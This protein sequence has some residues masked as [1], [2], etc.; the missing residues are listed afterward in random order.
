M[1]RRRLG[2]RGV[3]PQHALARE[4]GS[5]YHALPSY[6]HLH[7]REPDPLEY[8]EHFAVMDLERVRYRTATRRDALAVAELVAAGFATYRAFAPPG[9]QPRPA[10]Q[11][12]AELHGV[13]SSGDVRS[14]I[15]VTPE[16]RTAGFTAWRPATARTD[17]PEP[18]P[19]RAHLRALFVASAWQGT[20]LATELLAWS[21]GGM[22]DS[23]FDSAQLWTPT[24]H[25]RARAFYEREGW[26]DTGEHLYSPQLALDLVRYA[27]NLRA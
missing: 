14:R 9:W 12:E 10:M 13:L 22:R 2:K 27:I 24:D 6:H 19:G 7:S 26:R 17:P 5:L 11:E 1:S 16:A 25:T 15:A 20:G 23:G 3:R 4:A 8:R 21:V 18:I